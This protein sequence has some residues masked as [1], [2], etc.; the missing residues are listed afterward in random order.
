[1][2]QDFQKDRQKL[3]DDAVPTILDLTVISQHKCEQLFFIMWSLLLC[4][5]L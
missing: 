5:L 4:L 2:L 1:M 3:K